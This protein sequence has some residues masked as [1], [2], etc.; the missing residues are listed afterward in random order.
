MISR[1]TALLWVGIA[2]WLSACIPD[3]KSSLSEIKTDFN[4]PVYRQILDLQD[5][6][7]LDSLLM[8]MD[9]ADPTYRY[10]AVNAFA[11]IR[12][13]SVVDSL[14]SMLNDPVLQ[15][16]AVAAYAIGQCNEP[17]KVDR[18]VAAFRGK[19][20]I[21]IDNAY[22]AN[23]LEAIGKTGEVTHLKAMASVRTYR[24]TDTLLLEGLTKAIYRF[25]LRGIT[26]PEGT[27]RM[28]D[29]LYLPATPYKA[30]LMAANY[31]GRA[32][33]LDLSQHKI[34]LMEVFNKSSDPYI[35]MA[36]VLGFG[37]SKDPDF[38][39]VLRAGLL[40]ENDY[41]VKANVIRAL[42]NYEY[43]EIKDIVLPYL[44]DKNP[45]LAKLAS[46]F[47]LDHGVKEDF[48]LYQSYM[49]DSLH[50]A[51]RC[52][53]EA[54]KLKHTPLYFTKTKNFISEGMVKT[55]QNTRN[56]YE[57]AAY[58]QALG[59]DPFNYELIHSVLTRHVTEPVCKVA[60]YQAFGQILRDPNF[61]KAFGY[62]YPKVKAQILEYL[63]EGLKTGDAG[64]IAVIGEILKSPNLSWREWIKDTAFLN[65]VLEKLVLPRE[66]ES[67]NQLAAAIAYIENRDFKP[68]K[69]EYNHPIDFAV[70]QSLPDSAIAAVKT[71][72]GL[73]RIQLLR[74]KAPATVASFVKLAQ[75]KFYNDKIFHRV[76]PNFVIQTGCPR[77]DGYGSEDFSIRSELPQMYYD[78][79]G[80]VGM[81]SAGNHTEGTQWFITHSPAPHLDGNYTIFGKVVEGMDVVHNID[82]GD[83]IIE[84]IVVK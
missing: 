77:G 75:D 68:R 76:V 20:T 50:W 66:I 15:V 34:R 62:G 23:I 32:K 64:V 9:H 29:Y 38:I 82:I 55:I 56:P 4:D 37:K 33:G 74:R 36:L 63:F 14:L 45:H 26:A 57:K 48:E 6:Q 49:S 54:A 52:N 8:W 31:I 47:V 84:I 41:R 80:Y 10:A 72:K 53:L 27:A 61:F 3:T 65:T 2:W 42:G 7:S 69:P 60:A 17:A 35:R 78:E 1:C 21:N 70:I 5:R 11:S 24:I 67:Y 18:L 83:K 22:N 19:D 25:A 12:D 40:T 44:K 13:V 43:E 81:A 59:L 71:T 30:R 79:E 73:I 28:V 39:P 51:V 46:E 58:I 16:R